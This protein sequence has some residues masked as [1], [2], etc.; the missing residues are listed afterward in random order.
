MVAG[1]RYATERGKEVEG[2]VCRPCC[3]CANHVPFQSIW[4]ARKGLQLLSSFLYYL[5]LSYLDGPSMGA[6][7]G[8]FERSVFLR[9]VIFFG[10]VHF[11]EF[12]KLI[13][14]C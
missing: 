1:T 4:L 10:T 5:S 12:L 8:R 2:G 3:T 11:L 6:E 14:S 7:D 13:D 9:F